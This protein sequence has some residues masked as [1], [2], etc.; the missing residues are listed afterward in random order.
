MQELEESALKVMGTREGITR[1]LQ[2]KE[3][4][5]AVV[6]QAYDSKKKEVSSKGSYAHLLM[7]S[8]QAGLWRLSRRQSVM[9]MQKGRG[10]G[11]QK[12]TAWAPVTFQPT[13]KAAGCKAVDGLSGFMPETVKQK[14]VYRVALLIRGAS[15]QGVK[16]R[17]VWIGS[18]VAGR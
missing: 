4:E 12:K 2:E 17:N 9:S 5:L 18:E 16:A 6:R 13:P 3:A 10:P 11:P 1:Q 7:R 14:R 8:T 15:R